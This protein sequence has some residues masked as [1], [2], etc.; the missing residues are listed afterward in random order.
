MPDNPS[1]SSP[2]LDIGIIGSGI[3]GLSCAWL[4][5]KRHSVTLYEKKDYFGG[6]CNTVEVEQHSS[7]IPIDTGFIVYNEQN[8][9]NL[10]QLFSTLNVN[11][12]DSE[13]SFSVSLDR[14]RFE[15]GTNG[16]NAIFAQRS[17]L[18][19]PEFWRILK[20]IRKFFS[21]TTKMSSLKSQSNDL[22]L[23]E[24]LINHNYS[25]SFANKFILP[26]AGEI[27]STDPADILHQPLD[28]FLSFFLS[29]GLLSIEK[30]I[31]W[32][33]VTGGSQE[34]VKKIISELQQHKTLKSNITRIARNQSGVI[35]TGSD[36]NS[37]KHDAI[38]V[39]THANNALALLEQPSKQEKQ[40]LGAFRYIDNKSYLH[41]DENF[42]P[43]RKRTWSSWNF[44]GSDNNRVIVSYWM[45]LLQSIN[46]SR[47]FIVTL[48]PEASPKEELIYSSFS[49]SHP[50][51]DANSLSAQKQ[52]WKLQGKNNTL[53]CGSYFGY[54][55]HED[56]L[57]SGLAV[58]EDLG[59]I[60]RPWVLSNE[61]NRIYR[62]PLEEM[63]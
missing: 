21:Q 28:N 35:L 42:M 33:T 41:S 40:L 63:G 54:G 16:I 39:A 50:Y 20:D 13:M 15:F 49:Y 60:K 48:N 19:R 32:K 18:L 62:L 30:N 6:H 1:A 46:K 38:V 47:N 36:G 52:L 26:M 12:Q 24:F 14:G 53:F 57:Q 5:G 45:N 3:A 37:F 10:T 4:L 25:Q 56:A 9:P 34:Y 44:L 59:N 11:T 7:I 31:T 58:A 2:I 8:Y 17:N 61:S 43:K 29:H 55:F 23:E 22:T 51:F 27:W